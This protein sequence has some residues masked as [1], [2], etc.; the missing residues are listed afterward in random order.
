[1]KTVGLYF[2][3]NIS[4]NDIHTPI[5]N[6]LNEQILSHLSSTSLVLPSKPGNNTGSG[7]DYENLSWLLYVS[8]VV[9]GQ[10]VFSHVEIVGR[11]FTHATLD[12]QIQKPK[13]YEYPNPIEDTP[14]YF[15][16]EPCLSSSVFLYV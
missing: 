11:N 2:S 6:T 15:L 12:A 8:R 5:W 3:I 16:G 4:L 7:I 1:M 10:R 14:I 13:K 9:K